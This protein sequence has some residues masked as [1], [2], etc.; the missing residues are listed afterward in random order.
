MIDTSKFAYIAFGALVM[1]G[2]PLRDLPDRAEANT[3]VAPLRQIV[4]KEKHS[5]H[6]PHFV[7]K[8]HCSA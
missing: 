1:G 4:K 2:V 5:F 8:T 3:E 7:I 6:W